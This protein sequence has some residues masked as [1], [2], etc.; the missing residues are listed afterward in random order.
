[1][2]KPTIVWRTAVLRYCSTPWKIVTRRF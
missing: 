2:L 1:L